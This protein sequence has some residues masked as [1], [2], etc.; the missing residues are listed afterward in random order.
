MPHIRPKSFLLR[1][2][3]STRLSLL[4]LFYL[5]DHLFA[6]AGPS[7]AR[8]HTSGYIIVYK[9]NPPSGQELDCSMNWIFVDFGGVFNI[10][11]SIN[12][13]GLIRKKTGLKV[14]GTLQH[15]ASYYAH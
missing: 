13:S 5:E 8:H 4:K 10:F 6:P 15:L 3:S 1:Q 9:Q 7:M 12:H 2:Q 11:R 14:D